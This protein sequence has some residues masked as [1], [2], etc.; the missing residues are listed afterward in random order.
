MPVGSAFL[1]IWPLP[2]MDVE[3]PTSI[4]GALRWFTAGTIIFALGFEG[5]SKLLDG[6][7][8]ISVAS[9]VGAL[10]LL[11]IVVY[12]PTL[13]IEALIALAVIAA[14]PLIF[15]FTLKI[16]RRF[17]K[18]RG[19]MLLSVGIIFILVALVMAVIGGALVYVG[20]ITNIQAA[21]ENKSN[22]TEASL[23]AELDAKNRELAA[24]R[25]GRATIDRQLANA[26]SELQ[27]TIKERDSANEKLRSGAR[28][29]PAT[30]QPQTKTETSKPAAL[31]Q[32]D[33][34]TK[35]DIW[36]SIKEQTAKFA[37][38]VNEGDAIIHAW[39]GEFTSNKNGLV[40]KTIKF[41]QDFIIATK[42]LTRLR[43]A[44]PKY[45]DIVQALDPKVYKPLRA[46]IEAFLG[47]INSAPDE[48]FEIAIRP[49]SGALKRDLSKLSEWQANIR[50][51]ATEKNNELLS[52]EAK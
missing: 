25:Q 14:C 52:M 2:S 33:I 35:I 50:R 6:K 32:T 41:R 31:S 48:N 40:Q 18:G 26:R 8:A 12:W 44:Y 21:N 1:W 29:P 24:E 27:K 7:I 16:G 42:R 20:A 28:P 19:K 51:T 34:V 45:E 4:G 9:F 30:V 39:P 10:V 43:D 38:L 47:A 11:A 13:P 23:K 46:S 49:Y 36:R 17:S 5:V 22:P 3:L 15:Y 37:S